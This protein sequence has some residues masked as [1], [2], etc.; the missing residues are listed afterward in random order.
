MG[1][2]VVR[3]APAYLAFWAFGA[4]LAQGVPDNP[5]PPSS[6]VRFLQEVAVGDAAQT[7]ALRS[8]ADPQR[9]LWLAVVKGQAETFRLLVQAGARFTGPEGPG[10]A[11]LNHALY[12]S[13]ARVRG[14]QASRQKERAAQGRKAIP[15]ANGFDVIIAILLENG[16][17][18][19]PA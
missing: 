12:E 14:R 1:R 4:V 7:A 10:V 17:P 11:L 19:S 15:A 6:K 3:L 9:G 18:E 8:A 16:V 13:N 2:S 5:S